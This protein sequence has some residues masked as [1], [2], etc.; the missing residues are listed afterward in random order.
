M[1]TNA[2]DNNQ[3]KEKEKEEKEAE[4]RRQK[5]KSKE[6]EKELAQ[7]DVKWRNA[8]VFISSTFRDMHGERDYLTRYVFPE[9][10]ER[11]HLSPF[12]LTPPSKT[13]L[14]THNQ[15]Q[16]VACARDSGGSPMGSY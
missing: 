7:K 3:E 5:L 11:Y 1:A 13:Q 10:Q 2:D 8:R 4:E 16:P 9:L 12:T 15:V 6:K 14:T